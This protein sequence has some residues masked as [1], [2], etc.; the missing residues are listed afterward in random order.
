MIVE[1]GRK[2]DDGGKSVGG[3]HEFG[4][5]RLQRGG[6]ALEFLCPGRRPFGLFDAAERMLDRVADCG[7]RILERVAGLAHG[8]EV[9]GSVERSGGPG[10]ADFGKQAA[11]GYDAPEGLVGG[12]AV[13]TPSVKGGNETVELVAL[14]L[15]VGGRRG[16]VLFGRGFSSCSRPWRAAR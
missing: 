9:F 2:A 15:K 7:E 12:H 5:R 11:V 1:A 4:N 10:E 3:A 8:G 13:G 14:L 16:P 6:K